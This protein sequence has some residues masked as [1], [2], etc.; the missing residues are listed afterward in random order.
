MP[1]AET[2]LFEAQVTAMEKAWAE[3]T[4]GLKAQIAAMLEASVSTQAEA[5]S[6][7]RPAPRAGVQGRWGEQMLRNVLEAAALRTASTSTN[8]PPPTPRAAKANG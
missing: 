5:R 8:R 3:D 6:V 4:G 1:V 7:G 2:P